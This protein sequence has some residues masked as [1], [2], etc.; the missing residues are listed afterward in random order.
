VDEDTVLDLADH[1]PGEA[2]E[3]LLELATGG[4]PQVAKPMPIGTD[5]FAHPDAQR[6]F[7]VMND[8][9]NY[10]E[11][12]NILGTNGQ[13]FFIRHSV[14]LW[15]EIIMVQHEYLVPPVQEKP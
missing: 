8:M 2:A 15:R 12:S 4:I 5:P 14:S 6:R 9:K 11:H 1:L 13:F 7:R 3:A 10:S